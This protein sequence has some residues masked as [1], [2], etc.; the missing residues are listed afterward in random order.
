MR[1]RFVADRTVGGMPRPRPAVNGGG[2][3]G[4]GLC[5]AYGRAEVAGGAA[6]IWLATR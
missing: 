2:L 1:R 4:S 5:D 6:R 3:A